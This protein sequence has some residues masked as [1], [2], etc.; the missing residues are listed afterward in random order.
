MR[1]RSIERSLVEQCL[2]NPDKDEEVEGVRRCVKRVGN[3]VLVVI[4][5]SVNDTLVV[6]TAFITSKVNKYLP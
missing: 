3:R 2:G 5:R 1:Q 4:Y 6:I